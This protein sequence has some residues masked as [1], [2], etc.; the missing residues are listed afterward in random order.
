MNSDE[1]LHTAEGRPVHGGCHDETLR[2]KR[3]DRLI[4]C[5]ITR[6]ALFYAETHRESQDDILLF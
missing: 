5:D 3:G 1:N 2:E 4:V 6:G